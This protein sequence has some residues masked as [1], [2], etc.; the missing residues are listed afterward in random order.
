VENGLRRNYNF[1]IGIRKYRG[2]GHIQ[3][4]FHACFAGRKYISPSMTRSRQVNG[5][6]MFYNR[7][8]IAWALKMVAM[9][10]ITVSG[11]FLKSLPN[12]AISNWSHRYFRSSPSKFK[13]YIEEGRIK[14]AIWLSTCRWRQSLFFKKPERKLGMELLALDS[15]GYGVQIE[16]AHTSPLYKMQSEIMGKMVKPYIIL[17][18]FPKETKFRKKLPAEVSSKSRSLFRKDH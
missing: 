15:I 18:V 5:V 7:G 9:A 11:S 17:R 1:A 16:S 3:I 14:W 12:V 4:T 6:H 8:A 10:P 13:A 2:H